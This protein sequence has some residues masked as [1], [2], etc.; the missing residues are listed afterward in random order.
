VTA[1]PESAVIVMAQAEC[2]AQGEIP[3]MCQETN[4]FCSREHARRWQEEQG[5]LPSAIVT[6]A[7]A[8]AVGQ[9][10]WGRFARN[11]GEEYFG[12]GEKR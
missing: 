9:A 12:Q 3:T 1:Q 2:C 4:F 11:R 10:I 7:D 6:V 8:A 5:T